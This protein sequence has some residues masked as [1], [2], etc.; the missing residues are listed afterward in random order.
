MFENTNSGSD[1]RQSLPSAFGSGELE[2]SETTTIYHNYKPRSTHGTHKMKYK[3]AVLPS[4][5]C[6]EKNEKCDQ[7]WNECMKKEKI[8]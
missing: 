8:P 5:T 6:I 7:E 4:N 2:R 1:G 3:N